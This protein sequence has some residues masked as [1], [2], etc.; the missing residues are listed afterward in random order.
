MPILVLI[1]Q[2]V[3]TGVPKTRNFVKFVYCIYWRRGDDI[4]RSRW[5]LVWY[6]TPWVHSLV[7]NLALITE[8]M[9]FKSPYSS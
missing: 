8:W 9:G 6:D 1:G 5:N 7:L 3:G 2:G 4:Y